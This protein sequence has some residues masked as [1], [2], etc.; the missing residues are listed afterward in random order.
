MRLL[1]YDFDYRMLFSNMHG[2]LCIRRA[3]G[4]QVIRLNQTFRLPRTL[5]GPKLMICG[6]RYGWRYQRFQ[7]CAG[8]SL[9][10]P[11]KDGVRVANVS[12]QT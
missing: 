1:N 2:E 8:N 10:V 12:T 11:A 6:R 4:Q 5:L 7:M 9:N 3:F